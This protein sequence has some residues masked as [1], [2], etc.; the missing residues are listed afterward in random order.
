MPTVPVNGI[1]LYYEAHGEGPNIVFCHGAGGNHLSWWQQV[2]HFQGE[3]RC[4][5]FDH[6]GFGRS[7]D[8]DGRAS[9]AYAEDLAALLD[10]LEV[11]ETYLVAQSMGGRSAFPLAMAQPQRVKALVMA[12]TV[13]GVPS[14]Q[15]GELRQR[16]QD[17]GLSVRSAFA[18]SFPTRDPV[19]TFLY[20]QIS[21]LNPP[22]GAAEQAGPVAD[23]DL[24]GFRVPT[25]FL[26][27][28]EDRLGHP[29]VGKLAAS[30]VPGARFVEVP[31]AGHSVY[32]ERSEE[33]NDI[34]AA[35]FREVGG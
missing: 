9:A 22:R 1:G 28:A 18:P 5:T 14:R 25:L 26:Y 17:E 11:Q 20:R 4:I 31:G 2:P 12:D 15:V 23:G 29:E 16:M 30:I 19:R 27:G 13:G 10:H 34:V 24:S 35:F 33:F 3:Y 32:F 8:L 21:G 7:P 6:R